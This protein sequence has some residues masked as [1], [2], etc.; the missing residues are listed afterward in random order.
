MANKK[1][2]VPLSI[3]EQAK[4]NVRQ[5]HNLRTKEG[6]KAL[7]L[8][9]IKLRAASMDKKEE[10][11]AIAPV[12]PDKADKIPS[13]IDECVALNVNPKT[14]TNWN[15]QNFVELFGKLSGTQEQ[16]INRAFPTLFND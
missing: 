9:I 12:M 8:E 4:Q 7:E 16:K 11:E 6:K 13:W 15:K 1:I 14:A 3:E 10:K 2:P 5:T